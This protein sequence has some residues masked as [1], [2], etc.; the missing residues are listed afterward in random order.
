MSIQPHS[1]K[2]Q[3]FQILDDVGLDHFTSLQLA[4]MVGCQKATADSYCSE[5]KHN[6][7]DAPASDAEQCI[8]CGLYGWDHNSIHNGVCLWCW[9]NL[10]GLDLGH[11]V[12]QIGWKGVITMLKTDERRCTYCEQPTLTPGFIKPPMCRH[13]YELALL[14][15]RLE[16]Q[17]L[18]VTVD[19]L[20][21]FLTRHCF[22][23]VI[24]TDDI[25]GLLQSMQNGQGNLSALD[26]D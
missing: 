24:T 11:L 14:I 2:Q 1:Y 15:S 22:R 21:T 19:N 7:V 25:P 4:Q 26:G 8:Y 13:H 5:W 16:R 10:A 6:S 18:P 17:G 12:S 20:C 3:I 23:F 9:A